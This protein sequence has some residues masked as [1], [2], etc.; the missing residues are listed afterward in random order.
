VWK[1][2]LPGNNMP[3]KNKSVLETVCQDLS[4]DLQL[5]SLYMEQQ[6]NS[7]EDYIQWRKDLLNRACRMLELFVVA[8]YS[9]KA[10]EKAEEM[11]LQNLSTYKWNDQKNKMADP[12]RSIFHWEHVYPV[13]AMVDALLAIKD[14]TPEKVK[15]VIN[16]FDIAWI[17]KS[18][19]Q[20]LD[21]NG[22]KS[23]RP[24]NPWDAYRDC[25]IEICLQ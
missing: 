2:I 8:N 11:G 4:R 1:I 24:E 23:K 19:N 20:R 10:A 25:G 5:L 15:A 13:S 14:V 12:D 16:K 18:E 9:Q 6:D 3:W 7:S 22:Y 21:T 17:L